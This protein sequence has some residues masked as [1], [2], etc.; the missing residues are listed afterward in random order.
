MNR[1]SAGRHRERSVAI[2]VAASLRLLAMTAATAW[3]ATAYGLAMTG[4]SFLES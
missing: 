4:G 1:H 3:I 2:Q